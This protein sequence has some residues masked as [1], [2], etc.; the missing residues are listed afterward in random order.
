MRKLLT[1][2]L[3]LLLAL[4]TLTACGSGGSESGNG[5]GGGSAPAPADIEEQDNGAGESGGDSESY[6]SINADV[7]LPSQLVSLEDAERILGVELTT[8]EHYNDTVESTAPWST[9]TQYNFGANG[10]FH[11]NLYQDAQLDI[12]N[13]RVRLRME[14]GGARGYAESVIRPDHE[15]EIEQGKSTTMIDGIGDWAYLYF[16]ASGTTPSM[17]IAYGDYFI[18]MQNTVKPSP[19]LSNEES[20]EWDAERLIELGKLAVERLKALT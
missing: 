10:Y 3:V 14:E 16:F 19:D 9:K 15:R 1:I 13:G 8:N 6:A 17:S 18:L 2:A 5:G 20:L 4:F 11:I 12:T 7:I